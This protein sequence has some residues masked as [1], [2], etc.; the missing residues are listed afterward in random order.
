MIKH[1]KLVVRMIKYIL[2]EPTFLDLCD[3]KRRLVGVKTKQIIKH[4]QENFCDDEET[5]EEIL[6]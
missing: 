6:K 3:N 4:M 2:P 5:E 1:Q